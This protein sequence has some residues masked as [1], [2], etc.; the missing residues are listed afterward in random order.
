LIR[1]KA[2]WLVI[3][4]DDVDISVRRLISKVRAQFPER[5]RICVL[6]K[7]KLPAELPAFPEVTVL[8][9]IHGVETIGEE[10]I[11]YIAFADNP[12]ELKWRE[13]NV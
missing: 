8:P 13:A 6:T 10:L 9:D 5:I 1:E 4:C 2:Y 3:Y 11:G 12:L 7:N